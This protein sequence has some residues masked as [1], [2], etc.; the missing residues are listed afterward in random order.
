MDETPHLLIRGEAYYGHGEAM[1]F[2]CWSA[3]SLL[4]EVGGGEYNRD[5]LTQAEVSYLLEVARTHRREKMD[6][7]ARVYEF[8]RVSKQTP[9]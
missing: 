4:A 6:H 2:T 3:G 8:R 9:P 5:A 1:C 7:D